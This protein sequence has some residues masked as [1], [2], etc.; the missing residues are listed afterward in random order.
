M[1][2]SSHSDVNK[3]HSYKDKA[4]FHKDTMSEIRRTSFIKYKS[5]DYKGS[6]GCYPKG[7]KCSSPRRCS[8]SSAWRER[9]MDF[10]PE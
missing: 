2:S 5:D 3:R 1:K 6:Q 7:V 10:V 9:C 4:N 8:P